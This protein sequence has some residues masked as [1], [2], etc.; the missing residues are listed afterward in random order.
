MTDGCLARQVQAALQK[1]DALAAEKAQL[2]SRA[3]AATASAAKLEDKVS[4]FSHND[5]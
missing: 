5:A 2:E 3:Q 1:G 4:L